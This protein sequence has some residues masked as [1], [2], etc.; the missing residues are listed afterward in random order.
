MY[1]VDP[2]S[3]IK[4]L[5]GPAV[6]VVDGDGGDVSVVGCDHRAGRQETNARHSPNVF[7]L[8]A[9][10]DG[11]GRRWQKWEEGETE[12]QAERRRRDGKFENG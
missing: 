7:P 8:L 12:R 9:A 10:A 1:V 2:P 11:R 4:F 3:L 5:C 6:A